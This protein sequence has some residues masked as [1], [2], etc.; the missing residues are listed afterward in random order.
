MLLILVALIP[1]FI[2]IFFTSIREMRLASTQAKNNVLTLTRLAGRQHA[3]SITNIH[4][5]LTVLARAPSIVLNPKTCGSLFAGLPQEFSIIRNFAV[6]D[7]RGNV[8]C[9]SVD[10]PPGI[11]FGDRP[12]LQQI[13][14]TREFAM[15]DYTI[16]RLS[17]QPVLIL[18]QPILGASGEVVAIL[19][20]A[21]KLESLGRFSDEAQ[22]PKGS[23]VTLMDRNGR[24]IANQPDPEKWVGHS[25]TEAGIAQMMR[26]SP[27]EGTAETTGID[28]VTRFYAF[29]RLPSQDPV[30]SLYL[31]IGV[32]ASAV[33]SGVR[34]ILFENLTWMA[35]V[36]ILVSFAAWT[37]GQIFI[38]KPTKSLLAATRILSSGDLAARAEQVPQ[39]N[40]EFGELAEAFNRMAASLQNREAETQRANRLRAQ[41]AAIVESSSDAII[42]RDLTGNI[43]SWNKAAERLFG[44]RADEIIG[45]S[46]MSLIPE[47]D[48]ERVKNNIAR[49]NNG[50]SVKF[51]DEV[52]KKK[53]GTEVVVSISISPVI[54][55]SGNVIGAASISRDVSEK[56]RMETELRTQK[57]TLQRIFDHI[58][59]M[60]SFIGND[61][62][63]RMV[64]REWEH[65]LGW[66]LQEAQSERFDPFA[67]CF[68]EGHERERAIKFLAE[69]SGER[70][71]FAITTKQ[72]QLT[73]TSWAA[74]RLSDGTTLSIGRERRQREKQLKAL[75]DIN[76]SITSSLDL[77]TILSTLLE[78]IDVLLPYAASHIRLIDP[79]TGKAERLACRNLDEQEWKKGPTANSGVF[80]NAMS[81]SKTPMVVP[82][83]AND[84]RF[85]RKTFYTDMGLASFLGVPLLF[86]DRVLG[87]LSVFTKVEHNFTAGEITFM[88]TLAKQASI[89]IH[90]SQLYEKSLRL[91]QD[92][93]MRER[94]IRT[95]VKGLM[96]S[97]D[98]EAR[99]IA[100]VLH[101]ES[102]QVL[103]AV[104]IALD[105]LA[106]Q[107]PLSCR[108]QIAEI[109]TLL[110]R[111]EDRLRTLSHEIHPKMLDHLG[112]VPCLRSLARQIS[113]RSHTSIAVESIIKRRLSAATELAIYRIVQEALNN[114]VRHAQAE[115][116]HVQLVEQQ[117]FIQCSIQDDGIGFDYERVMRRSDY[118]AGLGL[119]G[120]RERVEALNGSLRIVSAPNLGTGL[121]VMLPEGRSDGAQSTAC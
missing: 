17:K 72:G 99:R 13:L 43:T 120:I 106:N 33:Y 28:G 97:R 58:P 62:R 39:R 85:R 4:H 41:L 15:S 100:S 116:V 108:L 73:Q 20:V 42:G 14:R 1:P 77:S 48:T 59:V 94:Q 117:G 78:K 53:D 45:R 8:I 2:I 11:N 23:V 56:R 24:V 49:V 10:L 64:N 35:I 5:T 96:N 46:Q 19:S 88:E 52:R 65:V 98:E 113:S 31:Y 6:T 84:P 104:Y 29:T 38:L 54:D 69:A 103:A 57:E 107:V 37:G 61:G 71:D 102:G 30:Q 110:D 118:K 44:Y 51:Y 27:D 21:L 63:I 80:A 87:F 12:W 114:A 3:V 32:P 111:V 25:F 74:I 92:V 67:A 121:F 22:L 93:Q 18:A 68:P 112:L 79:S 55:E 66:S 109:K 89:A 9:S 50:E 115:A 75:H 119:A 47:E 26:V 82:N 81:E 36:S 105:R 7:P 76:V 40:D 70:G 83:I 86:D 16:G 90:N 95:L 34:M 91:T 60:I 101:D